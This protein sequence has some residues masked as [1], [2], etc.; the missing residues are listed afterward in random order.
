VCE[1]GRLLRDQRGTVTVE[2]TIVTAL[3]AVGVSL[4]TA[5]L[6]VLLLDL[7]RY[8]QTLLLLPFP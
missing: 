1:V 7:F 6:G 5:G 4:A 2:Y 8:Q 3:I